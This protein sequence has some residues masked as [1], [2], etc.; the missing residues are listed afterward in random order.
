MR[1]FEIHENITSIW[2]YA[3]GGCILLPTIHIKT[4]TNKQN[5]TK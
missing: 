4:V 2:N 5:K 1:S 3:F